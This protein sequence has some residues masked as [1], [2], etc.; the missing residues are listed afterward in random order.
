MCYIDWL[1]SPQT[2]E[3]FG[4]YTNISALPQNIE[5]PSSIIELPK[6]R[7]LSIDETKINAIPRNFRRIENLE[8]LWG[9]HLLSLML[10][11]NPD[12]ER[13]ANLPNMQNLTVVRCPK[14]MVFNNVKSLRSI[15]LGIREMET[16]LAYLRDTKLEQLEIACSLKLLKLMVKKEFWSEWGKIS[17]TPYH[18]C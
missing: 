18:A 15:Q 4:G 17:N 6:L 3:I 7:H 1:V 2:L 13:I 8:M 14:L 12:L 9:F 16:L 5:L 10:M 11:T